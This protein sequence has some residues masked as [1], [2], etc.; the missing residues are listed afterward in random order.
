[1][2]VSEQFGS[3]S[4]L[5]AKDNEIWELEGYIGWLNGGKV[6]INADGEGLSKSLPTWQDVANYCNSGGVYVDYC[7]WPMFYNKDRNRNPRQFLDFLSAIGADP[8]YC[9]GF[10]A[11]GILVPYY[12]VSLPCNP[13]EHRGWP[14]YGYPYPR[15]WISTIPL[16]NPQGIIYANPDT[17]HEMCEPV[18][19]TSRAYV[20][21][22]VGVRASGGGWYF[23]G[24]GQH[25]GPSVG[26]QEYARF[27]KS[28]V[29]IAQ[30]PSGGQPPGG[31]APP[32]TPSP[33]YRT[34][35]TAYA[36]DNADL[37]IGWDPVPG[38]TRYDLQHQGDMSIIYSG[39]STS[40]RLTNLYSNSPYTVRVRACNAYGC[41]D[42]SSWATLWTAAYYP[43]GT[44]GTQ[45]IIPPP[46]PTP[47]RTIYV[48]IAGGVIIAAIGIYMVVKGIS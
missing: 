43:S 5:V 38:A 11:D 42:W 3:P 13:L 21:S 9:S 20:Y 41:S 15:G 40:V 6:L 7:G 23:Y 29:G 24:F 27:I 1:M 35:S 28:M 33:P 47:D 8:G 39:P 48:V 30:P 19:G 18:I 12:N 25:D 34:S 14:Y 46:R 37:V 10:F 2:A 32:G 44:E 17:P 26:A 31:G 4:R 45:P 36:L 16:D 22:V